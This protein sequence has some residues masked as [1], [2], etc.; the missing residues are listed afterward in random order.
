MQIHPIN[1]NHPYHFEAKEY[2]DGF[3]DTVEFM[4]A[5]LPLNLSSP[6]PYILKQIDRVKRKMDQ[7]PVN[8]VDDDLRVEY[9]GL[10]Y[11]KSILEQAEE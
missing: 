3:F 8:K 4:Q 7:T 5:T 1:P 10:Q 2:A 11:I 6:L 9:F